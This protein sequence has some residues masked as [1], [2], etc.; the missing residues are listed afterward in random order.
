[1]GIR[2]T[3]GSHGCY[4]SRSLRLP[5]HHLPGRKA[6]QYCMQLSFRYSHGPQRFQRRDLHR[7]QPSRHPVTQRDVQ[8][9][10]PRK[11][12]PPSWSINEVLNTLKEHLYEPIHNAPLDMLTKKMLFL[13]AAASARRRSEI[14]ALI[15]RRGF[16]RFDPQGVHLMPNPEFM[17]K[18]ESASFHHNTSFS[19]RWRQLYQYEKIDSPV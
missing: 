1:M 16:I 2:K 3:C 18:N 15:T 19:H 7:I 13:V 8:H 11:R 4:S 5:D 12:L 14:H 10:P 17:T 9:Q 6:S